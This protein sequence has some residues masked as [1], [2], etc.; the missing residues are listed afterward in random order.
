MP[1]AVAPSPLPEDEPASRIRLRHLST[2]LDRLCAVLIVLMTAF[3]GAVL[4]LGLVC[5]G[6]FLW[7]APDAAYLGAAPEG[8]AGLV[9]FGS[10]P[11]PTR[12]AYATKFVLGQMPLLLA[13]AALRRLLCGFGEGATFA[14]LQADRLRRI[15]LWLVTAA[16][17]PALGEI[18]V[19]AVG[20]GV[21]RAWFHAGS[22]Y[23]L[24]VA[25][26]LGVL[27]ALLRVGAAVERDRDGFV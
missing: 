9:P 26:L 16:L 3:G 12:L 27:E 5:S 11:W 10:L 7:L 18:L 22:A 25:A 14:A 4:I 6:A 15:A 8:V 23:I 24:L 20:H 13:L 2:W 19:A 1:Y 17:A 21:D